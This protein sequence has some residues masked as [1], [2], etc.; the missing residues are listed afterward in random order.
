MLS[1]VN[2]QRSIN[3]KGKQ[4][5]AFD[6]TN[7]KTHVFS[8]E[9]AGSEKYFYSI[10]KDG[11]EFNFEELFQDSDSF[12]ANLIEK[13]IND[14]SLTNLT[15]HE[16]KG[17]FYITALQMLRTRETLNELAKSQHLLPQMMKI[18]FGVRIIQ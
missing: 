18:P 16:R 4:I 7:E 17:L 14:C 2:F 3:N 5:F 8:I 13:I 15:D 6:K 1:K 10:R 12:L 9:N 11:I